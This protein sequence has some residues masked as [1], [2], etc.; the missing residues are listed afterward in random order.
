MQLSIDVRI[1]ERY[2]KEVVGA[3]VEI[4]TIG[5]SRLE[6]GY[7][8]AGVY[9]LDLEVR[10]PDDRLETIS[11][12]QKHTTAGEIGVMRALGKVP[13][14]TAVPTLIGS[15][16]D[17]AIS[18]D[19]VDNRFVT[20]FYGG[21]P[22]TFEDEVPRSVVESLAKVHAYFAPR[23]ETLRWLER[24]DADMLRRL[25]R[26]ALRSLQDAQTRRPDNCLMRAHAQLESAREDR[27]PIVL[28]G[29]LPVTLTHGDVHPG[30]IIR[31]ATGGAVLIDWGNAK[32]A[33]AMLDLA[34]TIQ[35]GSPNWE[36]Y[37]SMWEEASGQTMD[38]E[39]A[40]A[41]YQWGTMMVNLMYLLFGASQWPGDAQAATRALNM[42]ERLQDARDG[43]R[44]FG[45]L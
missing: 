23:I 26:G 44:Q 8:A 2:G 14:A 1:L 39:V 15:R 20:P 16:M 4:R 3:P 17:D 6:G 11:V 29:A 18:A 45:K 43:M 9:R 30:N 19:N 33:P 10:L 7:V 22:L 31:L 37:V 40:T 13:A 21:D 25:F 24:A 35:M 32:V 36:A 38:I 27:V 34:N 12:V 28:M 5:V 41:A 42:A